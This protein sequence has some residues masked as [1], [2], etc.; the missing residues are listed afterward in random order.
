MKDYGIVY[1]VTQPKAIDFTVNK[2]YISKDVIQTTRECDGIS[3]ECYQFN[4]IEYDKDEYILLLEQKNADIE[5]LR[6]ELE[7]AKIILGVE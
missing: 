5:A 6:E 2:V 1:S 3:E 4:L 7:A